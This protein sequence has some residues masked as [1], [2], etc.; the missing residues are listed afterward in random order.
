MKTVSNAMKA[1]RVGDIPSMLELFS[2]VAHDTLLTVSGKTANKL[3]KEI[4]YDPIRWMETD[5]SDSP[6]ISISACVWVAHSTAEAYYFKQ[7]GV[8]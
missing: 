7:V 6:N 1:A 5:F 3:K 8:K 4:G 2:A